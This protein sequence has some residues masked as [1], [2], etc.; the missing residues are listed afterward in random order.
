[1]K[2]KWKN[3]KMEGWSCKV[4]H[5]QKTFYLFL[6]NVKIVVLHFTFLLI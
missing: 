4:M 5:C 1:M 2:R 3:I 6:F